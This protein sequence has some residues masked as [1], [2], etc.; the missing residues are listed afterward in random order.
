MTMQ[1]GMV[2]TDGVLIA[3]DTKWA[4]NNLPI[5]GSFDST[6]FKIDHECGIAVSCAGSM[7]T[8]TRLADEI[9]SESRRDVNWRSAP[10]GSPGCDTIQRI[11]ERVLRASEEGR[12]NAQCIIAFTC[13]TVEL[14]LF[15]LARISGEWGPVCQPITTKKFAGDTKNPAVFWAE[16]YYRKMPIEKL[17]P[18]AAHLILAASVLNS[19]GIG[20]LEIVKCN[21]SGIHCCSDESIARLGSE[22][23][24]LDNC[25]R[26]SLFGLE[27]AGA[28]KQ[29]DD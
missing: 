13:P 21:A 24:E 22:A 27:F 17:I 19:A 4:E 11:G 3:S 14:W 15:E 18:L 1:V 2:G 5:R 6:K 28:A 7:N 16:R 9:V 29:I 25:I 23:A 8:A 12:Q 10:L 26:E 20:G